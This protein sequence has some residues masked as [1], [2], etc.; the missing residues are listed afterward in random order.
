[1]E[2]LPLKWVVFPSLHTCVVVTEKRSSVDK[3]VV[4][5]RASGVV[6]PKVVA[7]PSYPRSPPLWCMPLRWV[8][9]SAG[10]VEKRRARTESTNLT[11]HRLLHVPSMASGECQKEDMVSAGGFCVPLMDT[12]RSVVHVQ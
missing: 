11:C 12:D 1:M 7:A 5:L 3:K 6:L 4:V 10:E 8:G 2:S 9:C